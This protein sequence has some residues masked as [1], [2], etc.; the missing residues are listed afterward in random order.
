MNPR[1]ED[2]LAYAL[3]EQPVVVGINA[4]GSNFSQYRGGKYRSE[5]GTDI[6]HSVLLVGM[7]IDKAT[8]DQYWILKNS[9]SEKWVKE[10]S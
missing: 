5:C 10:G 4:H 7:W 1:N 6:S 3:C 9:W 2:Q 8:I